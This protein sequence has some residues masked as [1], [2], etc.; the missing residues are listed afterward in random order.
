MGRRTISAGFTSAAAGRDTALPP[1]PAGAVKSAP[2]ATKKKEHTASTAKHTMPSTRKL[3]RQPPTPAGVQAWYSLP[4]RKLP[5]PKP[6]SSTPEIR[7]GRSGNQ[8]TMVLITA[9]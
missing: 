9:L 5:P 4:I 1:L 2:G 7:P 3:V 8:R 6:I